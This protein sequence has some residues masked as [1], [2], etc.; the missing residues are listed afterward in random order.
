MKE[1]NCFTFIQNHYEDSNYNNFTGKYYHFPHKYYK[2]LAESNN[3]EF[4]YYESSTGGKGEYFGYGKVTKIFEDKTKYGYYFA[5]ISDYKPFSRPVPF[6]DEVG[7]QREYGPSY[8]AQNAVRRISP[9]I[10]DEICLDGGIILNFKTD[11]HLVQ[12]L[13][14]QLIE[15]ERVGI[16][17]LVKNGFDA[18]ASYTKVRIEKIPGITDTPNSYYFKQ[19]KGPVI[20]IED[21]GKGMSKEDIEN[22]WLRPA[23]TMKT[24]IKT[25]IKDE[26]EKAIESGK[27]DAF[28]KFLELLKSEHKGRIP[29]GEKGVGRFACHRLGKNLIIKTKTAE[30]D[31]EFILEINWDDF[32]SI[33]GQFKNLD[34]VGVSLRR[35]PLSRSYGVKNSGTQ[36]IIYGGREGFNLD[37]DEIKRINR[38]IL[39]LNTPN[40]NP[41]VTLQRFEA[42]FEC[43]Q[44]IGLH[45]K[46]NFEEFEPVFSLWGIVNEMGVLNFDFKFNPPYHEEIPLAPINLKNQE[47]DL[48]T[49]SNDK[50]DKWVETL[51]GKKHWRIPQCGPFYIHLDVWYRDKP[52]KNNLSDA[53]LEHLTNFG[54]ISIYRDGINVYPA[55]WGAESDW[56][57]LR[58]RQIKQAKR[59]SYYH[60]LGNVEIQQGVNILLIDKTNREGMVGNRAAKDLQLLVKAVTYYMENYYMG[61]RLERSYKTKG[62]IRDPKIIGDKANIASQIIQKLYENYQIEADPQNIL[63]DLKDPKKRRNQIK[64]IFESLS[65]LKD[66]LEQ[67]EEVHDLLTE[68]AGFGLGIAVALHEINKTASN[69]YYGTLEMLEDGKFNQIKLEDLKLQAEAL[70]TELSRLSPLRALRNEKPQLLKISRSIKFVES[71]FSKRFSD[72]GIEFVYNNEDFDVVA[73]FSGLNQIFTNLLDNSC[74]WINKPNVNEKRIKIEVNSKDRHVIVA[75]SGKGI[76]DS[77]LPYLFQPGYS[78]KDQP[79]GLGTYICRYYMNQMSK[80]GEIYLAKPKDRLEN[81]SGAQFLLDF[82]NVNSEL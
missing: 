75:D 7:N 27:E 76:E 21:D 9:E 55:E 42:I 5:E 29:L 80:R 26:R 43:P 79:S 31:Y 58:Q 46:V 54:G 8:N 12:I 24:N 33:D 14:E 63:S 74:Y 49:I 38:T 57:G 52:W 81:Y 40:Q 16:L 17:E 19:Y 23:S 41:N 39:K 51:N 11:S 71:I 3:I 62:L 22:G 28:E 18:G 2:Q 20:I 68:Q 10:L 37:E 34:S 60:I 82:S 65:K 77:I 44:V 6:R 36:I 59:M 69:F 45:E 35:Q 32:N 25:R 73:R 66:S 48:R 78:L 67:M 15:S 64:E 4:V 50:D 72:L 1:R 70:E 30:N 56:I 13:G 53:F 47:I 61:K